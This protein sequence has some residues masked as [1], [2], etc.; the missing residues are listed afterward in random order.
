MWS[1]MPASTSRHTRRRASSTWSTTCPAPATVK[2]CAAPCATSEETP[3]CRPVRWGYPSSH[4]PHPE[5]L[6]AAGVECV[7]LRCE[8]LRSIERLSG[9]VLL[10]GVE[11]EPQR[12]A[13]AGALQRVAQQG[14]PNRLTPRRGNHE[15]IVEVRL[16]AARP[17]GG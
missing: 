6:A 4:R 3:R 2:Y 8:S 12:P 13:G 1:P 16:G 11:A 5:H 15:Q 14:A 7:R 9:V 17:D 10:V